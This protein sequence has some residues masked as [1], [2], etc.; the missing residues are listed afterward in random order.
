MALK[1]GR[2]RG[3]NR[4]DCPIHAP[5]DCDIPDEPSNTIPMLPNKN[6]A[7]SSYTA[8]VF[9]Y[10]IGHRIHDMFSSGAGRASIREYGHVRDLHDQVLRL[11]EELPPAMRSGN[12]DKTW[13]HCRPHFSKFRQYIV[14]VT[15]AFIMGLHRPYIATHEA[16]RVAAIE[17]ALNILDSQQQLFDLMS[18]HHYKIYGF[19]FYSIDAGILLSAIAIR[20]VS[21]DP[22]TMIKIRDSLQKAIGRLA[23]LKNRSQVAKSGEYILSRC[24]TKVKELAFQ[25]EQKTRVDNLQNSHS[26]EKGS[27]MDDFPNF[28]F[29]LDSDDH[30]YD[31]YHNLVDA[32]RYTA[33]GPDQFSM[34]DIFSYGPDFDA[35]A[36]MD[37]TGPFLDTQANERTNNSG[38]DF[39]P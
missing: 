1:L 28:M 33:E 34:A 5:I 35:L 8:Q 27:L 11:V 21:D 9:L 18:E 22:E 2:P 31:I 3:I 16:S 32:G 20:Q 23:L 17:A 14:T 38:L 6:Q 12:P 19:S 26:L 24:Y 13:D 37:T 4:E 30:V 15:N 36:F 10:Q 39:P 25:Q 29:D 7:P